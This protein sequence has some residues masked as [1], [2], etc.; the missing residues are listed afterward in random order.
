M[1]AVL[2][3]SIIGFAFGAMYFMAGA[4]SDAPIEGDRAG[5]AGLIIMA[6]SILG[7]IGSIVG[8]VKS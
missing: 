5:K 4:M 7:I 3:V 1:I 2:I 8:L 6:F